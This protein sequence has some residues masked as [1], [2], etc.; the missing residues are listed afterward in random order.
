[1]SDPRPPSRPGRSWQ[2]TRPSPLPDT[3]V[4]PASQR[5]QPPLQEVING[6]DARELEG[7]TVFDQLFGPTPPA[8]R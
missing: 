3:P 1:M 4:V 5:Q 8:P 2:R 7:E 6:L